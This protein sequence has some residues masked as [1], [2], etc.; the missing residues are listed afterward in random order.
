M[1]VQK[2][3]NTKIPIPPLDEQKRIVAILDEVFEGIDAAIANTE[4][5]LANA[6]ELFESYLNTIFT[7][8]GDDW[9]KKKLK[10]L[11]N[12]SHGYAFKGP[13]F[14]KSSDLDK[15]IVLTPGNYSE[16]GTLYFTSQN[17]K[18]LTGQPAPDGYLFDVGDLTIVMTD[19]SSKMKILGKP[20]FIEHPN[21]LHNQRIGRIHFQSDS[22][23]PRYVYY[24]LRTQLFS[25]S[26]KATATG[27]MVRHTAPKR[28]LANEI[29]YPINLDEQSLIIT[30]L[31][32]LAMEVQKLESIYQQKLTALNELKQSILQKA[33]S[34]EL[35]AE[36]GDAAVAGAK[37]VIAA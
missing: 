17:T 13:D 18:R 12:I 1:T 26:I 21:I 24:F 33:F 31:D 4:K 23:S 11:V 27:T 35:T 7:R 37:E 22:V 16:D 3:K 25:D 19:L 30:Q 28:I 34:G 20:A 10:D 14:E 36:V 6:R 32:E 29:L 9:E 5:N 2:V 8:K 15:P